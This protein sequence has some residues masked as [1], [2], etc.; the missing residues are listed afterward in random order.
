[1]ALFVIRNIFDRLGFVVE[2]KAMFESDDNKHYTEV[3]TIK[4]GEISQS[5]AEKVFDLITQAIMLVDETDSEY[6]IDK[7]NLTI[8]KV[9]KTR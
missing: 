7:K 8:K 3:L 9:R 4:G 1:M 5:K 2:H 6:Q